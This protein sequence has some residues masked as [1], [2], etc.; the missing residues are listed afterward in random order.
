MSWTEPAEASVSW[1]E[2]AEASVNWMEPAGGLGEL[3]GT[4]GGIGELDGTSGGIGELAGTSGGIGELDGT[5][6][7]IGELAGTSGGI[8]ELDGTSGGIDELDGISGG[9]SIVA[10]GGTLFAAGGSKLMIPGHPS[11][12]TKI[13]RRLILGGLFCRE[14]RQEAAR[15]NQE[16]GTRRHGTS[17]KH[18]M[19]TEQRS[20]ET[21]THTLRH[22]TFN[23]NPQ[24]TWGRTDYMKGN[25]TG[26]TWDEIK[27][28]TETN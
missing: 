4:S 15:R 27:I 23:N 9:I 20:L 18:L 2:P 22:L 7:G 13:S 5:S 3:A 19:N 28:Q 11:R 21:G 26:N 25:I 14:L 1:T 16:H 10:G 8:G 24:E 12:G 17:L 6:G